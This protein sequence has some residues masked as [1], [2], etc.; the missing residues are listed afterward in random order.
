MD[1][2]REALA[3]AAHLLQEEVVELL[4]PAAGGGDFEPLVEFAG[5]HGLP[6]EQRPEIVEPRVKL[7][8]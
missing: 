8:T 1:V 7:V 6:G 5:I 2:R 4:G 3:P